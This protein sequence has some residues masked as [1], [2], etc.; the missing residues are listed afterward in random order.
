MYHIP[1]RLALNYA[2]SIL[3]CPRICMRLPAPVCDSF[4]RVQQL[5]FQALNACTTRQGRYIIHRSKAPDALLLPVSFSCESAP[6]LPRYCWVEQSGL[7]HAVLG[8]H[9]WYR[10]LRTVQ[11]APLP[12]PATRLGRVP[13]GP[14]ESMEQTVRQFGLAKLLSVVYGCLADAAS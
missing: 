1:L 14:R 6:C 10:V 9:D 13:V 8:R 11:R 4:V 12:W 5:R 2:E 7:M 3:E